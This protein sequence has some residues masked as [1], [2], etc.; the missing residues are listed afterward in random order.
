M[1]ERVLGTRVL[2]LYAYFTIC[3]VVPDPTPIAGMR[4]S[5][6][7]HDVDSSGSDVF[8]CEEALD[9]PAVESEVVSILAG[10]GAQTSRTQHGRDAVGLEPSVVYNDWE[11]GMFEYIC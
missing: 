2:F 5:I 8:V 3:F 1:L 11:K 6:G 10:E 4:A 9:T 7:P